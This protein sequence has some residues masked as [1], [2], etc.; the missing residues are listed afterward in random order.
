MNKAPGVGL[1]A[2]QIGIL[3]EIVTVS[4]VDQNTKNQIEYS[5]FNP[6]IITYSKEKVV[7]EEGCL[8]LPNQFAEIERSEKITLM[9]DGVLIAPAPYT[10]PSAYYFPTILRMQSIEVL[11]GASAAAIYGT[12][13][14]AG[15]IIITTKKGRAG[16]TKVSLTQNIGFAEISNRLGM[17]DWTAASV[18]AAFGASEVVKYLSLIHI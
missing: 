15:V 2:N 6:N 8:S 18:E 5:L 17:R 1:A 12:R 13:A 16:K 7:M 3:K 9:E 11:K 4:F 10:A 14:N